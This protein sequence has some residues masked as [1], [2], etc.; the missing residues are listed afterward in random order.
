MAQLNSSQLYSWPTL[1]SPHSTFSIAI[2]TF[3]YYAITYFADSL[4]GQVCELAVKGELL[5]KSLTPD[6]EDLL[7]AALSLIATLW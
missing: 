4:L 2:Y 7:S 5:M 6:D 1:V 3:K